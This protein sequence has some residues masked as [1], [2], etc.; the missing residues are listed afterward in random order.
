MVRTPKT[1]RS[2]VANLRATVR[3]G[4]ARNL[5]PVTRAVVGFEWS[6]P[7]LGIP[8]LGAQTKTSEAYPTA[9][10]AYV[11]LKTGM[12]PTDEIVT[13]GLSWLREHQRPEGEW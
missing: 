8:I 4:R 5:L 7:L 3:D 1:A 11:L 2:L 9:F 12:K 10:C 13:A 6:G